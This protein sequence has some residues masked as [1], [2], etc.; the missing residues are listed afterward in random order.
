LPDG[1]V[2]GLQRDDLSLKLIEGDW[3]SLRCTATLGSK[4]LVP[5]QNGKGIGGLQMTPLSI[6]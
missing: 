6:N 4:T 1:G 3:N 5:G 2:L